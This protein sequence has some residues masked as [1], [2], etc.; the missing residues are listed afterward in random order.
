[1]LG[2]KMSGA[3]CQKKYFSAE[4]IKP[5]KMYSLKSAVTFLLFVT[6]GCQLEVPT[7]WN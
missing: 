2:H 1:M 5:K 7:Y 4:V 6:T 3:Q